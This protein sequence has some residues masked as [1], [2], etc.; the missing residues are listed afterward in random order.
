MFVVC[1]VY[2]RKALEDENPWIMVLNKNRG[3]ELPGGE[4]S[5]PM[6]EHYA[7]FCTV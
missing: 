4:I 1:W 2:S 5:I 6:F 3:W 7:R